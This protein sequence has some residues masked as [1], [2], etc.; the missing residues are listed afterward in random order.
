MA[1]IGNLAGVCHF[2]EPK[3]GLAAEK[4]NQ[5]P[6]KIYPNKASRFFPKTGSLDIRKVKVR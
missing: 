6:F 1:E 5:L 3:K 4:V 2:L